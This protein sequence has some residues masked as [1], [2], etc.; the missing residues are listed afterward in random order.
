MYSES[1]DLSYCNAGYL[2]M[3]AAVGGNRT[4]R[5]PDRCAVRDALTGEAI[6]RDANRF[7]IEMARHE[8]RVFEVLRG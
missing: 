3:R 6:A 4:F 5:A 2:G 8:T 7:S 1:D